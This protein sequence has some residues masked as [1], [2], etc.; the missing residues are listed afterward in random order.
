TAHE[1]T[2]LIEVD[3]DELPAVTTLEEALAP[4]APLV[5]TGERLASHFADLST[6]KP[7]P[8]TNVCHRFDLA[9]GCGAAAFGEADVV[10]DDVYRFPRVQHYAMEPH[11]ALAAWDDAGALTVWAATQNPYSV[12]VELAKMFRVPLSRIRIIVPPLGGGFGS[13]TY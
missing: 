8:G 11:A 6:L 4:G 7:I 9:R 3:Y 5:H 2:D 10:V 1:A 12:R 13:K